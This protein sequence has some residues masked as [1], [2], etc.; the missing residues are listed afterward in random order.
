M[1][2]LLKTQTMKEHR[3][4]GELLPQSF[5]DC[6]FRTTPVAKE[7]MDRNENRHT[8]VLL[9]DP[10]LEAISREGGMDVW[11]VCDDLQLK[12]RGR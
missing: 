12:A 3:L 10:R 4:I 9:A 7:R 6:S 5:P 2:P 8:A 11:T 1:L